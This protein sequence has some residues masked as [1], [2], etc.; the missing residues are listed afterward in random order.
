[1]VALGWYIAAGVYAVYAMAMIFVVK[2][3][4]NSTLKYLSHP[5]V[6]FLHNCRA[7]ARYDMVNL[8]PTTI[9]I[10][11][12]L[13]FPIRLV[14]QVFFLIVTTIIVLIVKWSFCGSLSV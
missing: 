5:P 4:T 9:Y 7:A 8:N 10:G 13:I 12:L 6:N 11:A 1:M 3:V 2:V 14:I